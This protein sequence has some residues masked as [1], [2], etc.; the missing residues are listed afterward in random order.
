M[1]SPAWC[2]IFSGGYLSFSVE[3]FSCYFFPPRKIVDTKCNLK[4][5]SEKILPSEFQIKTF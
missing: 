5:Q 4:I 2:L 1:F 3:V